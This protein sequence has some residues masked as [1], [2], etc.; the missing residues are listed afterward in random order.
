MSLSGVVPRSPH[1]VVVQ[2]MLGLFEGSDCSIFL[3]DIELVTI[4]TVERDQAS[5]GN[6][7]K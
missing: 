2:T 5:L 3:V 4:D 7:G 1:V 6:M